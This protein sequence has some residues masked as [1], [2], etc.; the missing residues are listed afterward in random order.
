MDFP[1]LFVRGQSVPVLLPDAVIDSGPT[2]G[3]LET[4]RGAAGRV[5]L[6]PYHRARLLR[7]GRV[8]AALL[9]EIESFLS[10]ILPSLNER[11]LRLRLRLG[12]LQF[13]EPPH[14]DLSIEPLSAPVAMDNGITLHL[15]QTRLPKMDGPNPGCKELARSRYNRAMSELPV[16]D[17]LHDGLL[18]DE[19]GDLVETLRCNLLLRFA[20]RWHTPDLSRCGVRGVM[21]DWLAERTPIDECPLNLTSLTSAEEVAVC[22]SVRGVLPV[23]ALAGIKVWH[24]G[25][26][27]KHLQNL[28]AEEL[29]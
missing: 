19:Q 13:D 22:N 15:C 17:L 21:R 28:V 3:L 14:W 27:V 24:P 11:C 10:A 23:R 9:E 1:L 29:W 26:Q 4:M 18:L 5:P 12:H 8:A 16:S 7:A 25:P 20:G 2:P 6:W